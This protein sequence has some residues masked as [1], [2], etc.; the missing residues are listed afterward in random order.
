[1]ALITGLSKR[2]EIRAQQQMMDRVITRYERTIAR[3]I[4]R[5]MNQAAKLYGKPLW[6]SQV[7]AEHVE[8][9]TGILTRLWTQAGTDAVERMF[10]I[11]K[12]WRAQ[13]EIKQ[14]DFEDDFFDIDAPIMTRAVASW[15]GLYGGKAITEIG[16][17]TL[18]SIRDVIK[19][20]MEEGLGESAIGEMIEAVAPTKS[21]SRAQTIARTETH[22]ASQGIALDVA[23]TSDIVME[24]VW[25]SNVDERI[26]ESHI[27]MDN[28]KVGMYEDFTL[29]SGEKLSYPGDPS[30]LP[31]ETINCRC[32]AALVLPDM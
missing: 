10:N 6:E 17:S 26:R 27:E 3:E 5:A 31:E 14:D 13:R 25:Y 12:Q 29:P 8:N 9:M 1:M 21:A 24:K 4:A 2:Q 11:V 23:K 18:A 15:I 16:T 22:R 30:G 7:E 28:E 20:G 19:Q 32:V